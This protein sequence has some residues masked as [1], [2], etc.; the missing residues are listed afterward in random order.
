M[1][2]YHLLQ[3]AVPISSGIGYDLPGSK[4]PHGPSDPTF[5]FLGLVTCPFSRVFGFASSNFVA[6][7]M[8]HMRVCIV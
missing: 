6:H 7:Y 1:N 3:L 5:E 4:L 2:K 8:M